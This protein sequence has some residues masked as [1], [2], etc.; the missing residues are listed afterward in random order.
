[1]TAATGVLLPGFAG[2]ELPAWLARRLEG[3]LAG[4]C[5]FG[6]NISSP[7][8]LRRLT[9]DIFAANP[10]ALIAIDEEGGDVTRLHAAAGSPYPGNALLGRIDDVDYTEQVARVVGEELRLAGCNLDFAPDADVNS[11]PRNPVIGVR[12]FGADP[13]LAARHTAAWVRGLQASGTAACVKHFPG[14]GDTAED[15]HRALPVVDQHLAS[16]RKR[17]LVPFV[18]AIEAGVRSVMTSHILLPRID[19]DPATFSRAILSDLLRSELGFDGVIVTDALDMRGASGDTGIPLAAVR[20]LA[21]GCDLLCLGNGNTDE[22]LTG[23]EAAIDAAVAAGTIPAGRLEEAAQRVR[24]LGGLL[25]EERTVTPA[26]GRDEPSFDP[27][28][29]AR[30]FAVRSG[31][32]VEQ[33]ATLVTLETAANIAVGQAPWGPAAAGAPTVPLAEGDPLPQTDGQLI[34]I[35]KDNHRHAWLR[36]VADEARRR[37]PSTVVVDMGWPDE[38]REYADIATFGGS[39][40]AGQA[41]LTLLEGMAR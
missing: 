26:S 18:A 3:G 29:T 1:M 11:N 36:A 8:Q 37:N 27:A 9:A 38:G 17:E 16:L 31:V 40:H 12:S 13:A 23:I 32:V 14:H 35:G 41:L 33:G 21:A 20:A 22:E 7:E 5:L 24:R 25:A 4:V 34:L 15:S 10:A 30:A 6:L 2:T 28:R 19:S 39:R